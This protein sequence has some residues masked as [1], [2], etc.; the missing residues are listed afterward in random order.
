MTATA[1]KIDAVGAETGVGAGM[2]K[3]AIAAALLAFLLCFPIIMLHAESDN[4]GNLFLTWRPW[5]VLVIC[6]IAF[7]GRLA[8]AL[9]AARPVAD[10]PV[11]VAAAPSASSAFIAQYIAI[12][13]LAVI[14]V[15][16]LAVWGLLG[17][18]GSLKW[19][20]SYGIQILIY[21]M[22]GWGL[23]IV[24]GL[25][26]LLDLG[27]VA[28]YAVGAYAY[29]LLATTFGLSFWICLPVAGILA[30]FWGIILGFPVLRLRGDYLAIVTLAFGEMIRLVLINW[31]PFSGGYAG[32]ASIPKVS[33]FGLSMRDEP[34]GFA[35]FFHLEYSP[36][37][38][39]IF[40]YYVILALALITNF[41]TLR[42]RRLPI[43]RA[44]E[45]L[46]EDEIAC[47][48]LGINTRNTKLTAF[49]LGAFFG[50][51]AGSFFAVRQGFISPESFTFNE[52]AT[53]LAIVV[54]GGM[55]SQIGVALAA[56]FLIG[57]FELLRELEWMRTLM[58]TV[59][60][61]P[62]FDPAQYRGLLF[63]LAMVIM[64]VLRP[65]GFVSTRSPS[66]FLKERKAVSGSL[67]KE[68]HG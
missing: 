37:H 13:G 35:D 7:A 41:V 61:I 11:A 9:Y 20:D 24:V 66:I 64:M 14:V 30:A 52:S 19:I 59:F 60:G 6:A 23:N 67:V 22:L 36:I 12:F 68:G 5:A 48:S 10:R 27:Y 53:V 31:I 15:F 65:R 8:L 62:D 55:G 4:D 51:L 63:G 50:G 58:A 2:I 54:L 28:F 57:G 38:S 3:D 42:L 21:V 43:G 34:G 33:F 45:A 25:A 44:W 56:V 46:R 49:A 16:P 47:R 39:K 29:A 40:L 18:S 26:G 32:I 1:Q 17:S